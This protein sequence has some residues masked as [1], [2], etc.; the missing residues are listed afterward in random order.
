MVESHIFMGEVAPDYHLLIFLSL[1]GDSIL[2][3]VAQVGFILKR[4][5]RQYV[6][7]CSPGWTYP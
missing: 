7:L 3:Y 6:I 5:W 4:F 1:F 2:Y